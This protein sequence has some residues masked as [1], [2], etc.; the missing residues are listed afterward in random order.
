MILLLTIKGGV[1]VFDNPRYV[2]KGIQEKISLILQLSLWDMISN[3]P[4]EKDYLQ[5]FKLSSEIKSGKKVQVIEHSQEVPPYKRNFSY[6]CEE[7]V[8]A[9]LYAID[10][11]SYSTLLFASE[12]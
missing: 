6:F 4:C 3:I 8:T 7:P 12:Y 1:Q 2:T 11:E 9:K 5:I 10:S